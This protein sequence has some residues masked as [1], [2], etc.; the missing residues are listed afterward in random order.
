MSKN[1]YVKLS[2]REHILKRSETYVG[3][4][5]TEKMKM[6]VIKDNNLSNIQVEKREVN[7]NPAFIKLF[8]EILTNASDH[9]IRTNKVKMIKVIIGDSKISIEND[10]QTIPIKMHSVEKVYNA[11]LIFSHLLTGENYDDN[12][13]RVVGGRNG[14]GAKLVN[15]FSKKFKVECCDGK[16]LYRQWTKGNMGTI[17]KP[18]IT[19]VVK[20]TKP[21]TRITYYPDYSQFDFNKLTDDLRSI[22]YKRCLDVAAYIPNV[23]ISVDGK[24]IPVKKTSDWMKMH[25]PEGSEFFHEKLD[26]DWE[27]GIARST[28]HGFESVSIVNGISTHKGGTHVNHI[29]LNVSKDISEK[30][31]KITWTDVKNKLFLFLICKVPNPT[32]DTQTKENLTNRMTTEIHKNSELGQSVMRKIMKSDIVKSILEEQEVKE[33]LQLKKMG[34]GKKSKVNFPK[35]QDAN[36]AGT[37][38]SN[39]CHLFLCEGDCLHEDTEISVIRDSMKLDIKINDIMVDDVVITHKSN[40]SVVTSVSKKIKKSSKIYLK[41]GEIL[42]CSSNHKWFVYDIEKDDFL[43]METHKLD[44]NRHKMIINKNVNFDSFL[45]IKKVNEISHHKYNMSILTEVDEILSTF[46]H[47]FSVIDKSDFS[48][49]MVKCKDLDP[50]IHMIINYTSLS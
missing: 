31:K 8:D 5:N 29:S 1:K 21:Y 50:D 9:A 14:L 28:E 15:V 48:M 39:K 6:Y 40:L 41:N 23:R 16:K 11:E 26:N 17:D 36:K 34:G 3:S 7:N 43:F 12:E 10:G 4:K 37:R 38:E 24:T 22:M 2:Q 13:Q 46:N 45:K 27:V 42:I 49:K 20:G 35:L 32:F 18:E 25:L 44:L 33:K 19:K 30:L 47:K